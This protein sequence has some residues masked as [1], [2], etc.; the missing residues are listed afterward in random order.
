VLDYI[1]QEIHQRTAPQRIPILLNKDRKPDVIRSNQ[2]LQQVLQ[3]EDGKRQDERSILQL[4][5]EMKKTVF[6]MMR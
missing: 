5:T 6:K 3:K 4:D 1:R 2:A